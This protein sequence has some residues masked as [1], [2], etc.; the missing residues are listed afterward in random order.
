MAVFYDENDTMIFAG[1]IEKSPVIIATD[2][3]WGKVDRKDTTKEPFTG[4][5]S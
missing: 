4:Q 3:E 2:I 1:I 5:E